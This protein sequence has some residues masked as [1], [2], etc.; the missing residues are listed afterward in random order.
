MTPEATLAVSVVRHLASREA[1]RAG[2]MV[3]TKRA[4]LSRAVR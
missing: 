2:G 3:I 1:I 4:M